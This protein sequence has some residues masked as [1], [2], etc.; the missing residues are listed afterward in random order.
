LLRGSSCLSEV[1][2]S[3]RRLTVTSDFSSR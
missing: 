1:L 2:T 3:P